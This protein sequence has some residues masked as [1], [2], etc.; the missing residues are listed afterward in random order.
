MCS[1]IIVALLFSK[2]R[3]LCAVFGRAALV[4]G[5]KSSIENIP[6]E[7]HFGR[8][9]WHAIVPA[10][11][12]RHYAVRSARPDKPQ[13][14]RRSSIFN[15]NKQVLTGRPELRPSE[16]SIDSELGHYAFKRKS[17]H[18]LYVRSSATCSAFLQLLHSLLGTYT[19]QGGHSSY[20][21]GKCS[22][23]SPIPEYHK[24]IHG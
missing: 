19:I 8:Q 2:C 22:T 7:K 1:N 14:Q 15:S 17:F 21:Y 9:L 10:Q 18:N 6:R 23:S 4:L 11:T 12:E 24:I 3:I 13:C 16:T 5:L 20:D